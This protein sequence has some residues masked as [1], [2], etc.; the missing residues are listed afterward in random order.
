MS[1]M[2]EEQLHAMVDSRNLEEGEPLFVTQSAW[3]DINEWLI[4][5]RPVD[6]VETLP[7]GTEFTV[8]KPWDWEEDSDTI[9]LFGHPVYCSGWA[10]APTAEERENAITLQEVLGTQGPSVA[11]VDVGFVQ[12]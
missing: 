6:H 10:Q 9:V 5:N 7:D 3:D 1:Q 12:Q 4:E 2:N 8:Q 11:G